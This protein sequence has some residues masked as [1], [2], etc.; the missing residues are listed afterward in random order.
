ML[1]V[2]TLPTDRKRIDPGS[3]SSTLASSISPS[4]NGWAVMLEIPEDNYFEL[5]LETVGTIVKMGYSCVYVSMHRPYA[6]LQAGLSKTG[7]PKEK[8]W[9][10]DAASSIAGVES[11]QKNCTYLATPLSI[12]DLTRA[13]FQAAPRLSG[14]KKCLFL[15]SV[16]TLAVYQPLSETLRFAE[17][18]SRILRKEEVN[19]ILVNVANGLAQKKFIQDIAPSFDKVIRGERKEI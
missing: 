14:E 4:K 18:I 2:L 15:D 11:A 17:F 3:L 9:V 1:V 16:T 8:V 5:N 13:I 10:V 12:D 7:V 6:N 19:G